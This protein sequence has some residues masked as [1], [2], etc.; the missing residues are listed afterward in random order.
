MKLG[1]EIGFASV[2]VDG[3]A[4][5]AAADR[6]MKERDAKMRSLAGLYMSLLFFGFRCAGIEPGV[7][8]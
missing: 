7:N 8:L 2:D 5:V 3:G 1:A 6:P 4:S